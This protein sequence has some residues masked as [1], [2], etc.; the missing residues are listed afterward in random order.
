MEN[1]FEKDKI[2]T[3]SGIYIDVFNPKPSDITIEDIATG[4]SRQPRWS[5]QSK[6]FYSVARHSIEVAQLASKELKIA[7]LLHD[8]SEA[9]LGDMPSPIKSRLPDYKKMEENLMKCIALK[10]DF[11]YPLNPD[12]KLFDEYRLKIEWE[13]VMLSSRTS[14]SSFV[15]DKNDFINLFKVYTSW[16]ME[17]PY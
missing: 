13:N 17:Y 2:R 15:K 12:V 8:A 9:Y 7:A 14:E 5:G 16:P 3:Y 1:L 10:F 4:L 11:Q 6:V